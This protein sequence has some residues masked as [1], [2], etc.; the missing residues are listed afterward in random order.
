MK[1]C[2]LLMAMAILVSVAG[3]AGTLPFDPGRVAEQAATARAGP[4]VDSGEFL[5]DTTPSGYSITARGGPA[6]PP[7]IA[8]GDGVYLV[9]WK[10]TVGS[11]T[12]FAARVSASG[13]LLDSEALVIGATSSTGW[14]CAVAYG[15]SVFLVA[16]EH[17]GYSIRAARVSLAGQVLDPGGFTLSRG[18]Q[19]R[20]EPAL[21][22]NGDAFLVGWRSSQNYV[23]TIRGC[24]VLPDG[25]IINPEDIELVPRTSRL[26]DHMHPS[27]ASCGSQFLLAWASTMTGDTALWA[28]RF[29]SAGTPLDTAPI[30]LCVEGQAG[31]EPAAASGAGSYL[32]VWRTCE[33]FNPN[34]AGK[35]VSPDGAVLD[36]EL[37]VISEAWLRQEQPS[38]SFVGPDYVVT[39]QD[40]RNGYPD[41]YAARV[42]PAGALLDPEGIPV[43]VA[44]S[45]QEMPAIACAGD[46]G[47]L[48]AWQ[49][50][51]IRQGGPFIRAVRIDSLGR[52][53]G[54]EILV[55][56]DPLPAGFEESRGAPRL[57]IRLGTIHRRQT[58]GM[59]LAIPHL[60]TEGEARIC[61]FGARGT[62]VCALSV[63][64]GT[65][66]VWR[67][68]DRAGRPVPAG[69]YV[70][71]ARVDGHLFERKFILVE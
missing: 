64:T 40:G 29:D 31:N 4:P 50:R 39:W 28:K 71:R 51:R 59:R 21:A 43:C 30:Q 57:S 69:T 10:T 46:S 52:P 68:Q 12:L 38:V 14:G 13:V 32:V 15:G 24:V 41:I 65:N 16:W 9:C 60:L 67:Y 36:R 3:A 25:S 6:G 66:A 18:G 61:I 8:F 70:L 37:I 54:P 27:I 17:S 33:P 62:L 49:D 47:G 7:A 45:S 63:Q 1:T 56:G 44:D 53:T 2:T 23:T 35:R 34:L 11:D 20:Q 55:G 19:S 22:F 26:H 42:T 48:I 58:G 5:I